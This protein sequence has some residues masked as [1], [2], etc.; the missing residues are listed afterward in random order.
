VTTRDDEN[1]FAQ[2]TMTDNVM[3]FDENDNNLQRDDEND[4]DNWKEF[5][6]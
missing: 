2:T 6:I 1:A 5:F 4:N 3:M